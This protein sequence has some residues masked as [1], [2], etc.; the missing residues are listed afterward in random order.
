[1]NATSRGE[2]ILDSCRSAGRNALEILRAYAL[3]F[4]IL[5]GL[6]LALL[7][8]APKLWLAAAPIVLG[9][10]LV[11]FW[12]VRRP[13][14][15]HGT[16]GRAATLQTTLFRAIVVALLAVFGIVTSPVI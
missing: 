1:M 12:G 2:R 13:A 15:D 7:W 10:A 8:Q 11:V 9:L 16:A 3:V 5:L 6:L 4:L 14:S